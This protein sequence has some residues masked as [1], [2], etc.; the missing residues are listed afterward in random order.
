[1]NMNTATRISF[2]ITL[3]IPTIARAQYYGT[4][5][6]KAFSLERWEEDYSYLK[7]K[8]ARTDFWDPIKYVPLNDAGDWYISFGGQARYRYDYFNNRAFGPGVNDEDGFHLQR[9]LLNADLHL[10]EHLRTFVQMNSS[11]NDGREGGSRYGDEQHFDFQQAFADV[12]TSEDANPFAFLRVGRQEL[13]YGAERLVSPDDWRNVRRSFD[14]VKLSVSFPNDTVEM[15]AT[16]PVLIEQTQW[17]NDDPGT[18]FSGVYNVTALPNL[19][20]NANTKLDTYFFALN[21]DDRS[22]AS[23]DQNVYTLGAR[24]QAR[25]KPFD[26]DVEG[27]YQFGDVN[28]HSLSAWFL[29][30]EAGYTF[31]GIT[32][33]PRASIG[34]DVASGSPSADGRFNQLFPPTYTYLG[35]LYLFGRTN[36]IDAHA[37]VDL[38]LTDS[39]TLFTAHH[40][41]WRQNTDDGL[42]DLSNNVVRADNGS[43]AAYVGNE[44]DIALTWQLDR[45]ISAY[46]GWAHFFSGDFLSDT[47]A[48][49]D[50]DFVYASVTYTF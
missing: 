19:I 6:P 8:S 17:D 4:T 32:F 15:F 31:D 24:L 39:L 42:R 3:L 22:S 28:D 2:C 1:M 16:R 40:S 35:H 23:V 33:S 44:I 38:H 37:G 26:F 10:G 14:G 11:F 12:K 21:Q 5:G 29:A 48:S 25:P 20:E 34:V 47:G 36:V 18:V 30:T 7:D 50:V 13:I 45:H 9:Y 49:R 27:A 43:D 41:F 46:I